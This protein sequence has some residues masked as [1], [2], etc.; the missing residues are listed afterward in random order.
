ML[1]VHP[2]CGPSVQAVVSPSLMGGKWAARIGCMANGVNPRNSA[3]TAVSSSGQRSNVA[4]RTATTATAMAGAGRKPAMWLA[5]PRPN[6]YD[7]RMSLRSP[8]GPSGWSIQ[9]T[10]SQETN[11]V[12]SN[13]T[14]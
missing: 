9:R 13:A 7:A 6:R 10:I 5:Y 8:A 11:A 14:V 4:G 12:K 1:S 3:P 2:R